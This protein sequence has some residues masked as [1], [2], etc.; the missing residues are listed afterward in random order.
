MELALHQS[1][2]LMS[3]KHCSSDYLSDRFLHVTAEWFAYHSHRLGV[4]PSV[5]SSIT[6]MI[7]IKTMQ[8]RI[9]KSLLCTAWKTLVYRDEISC[10]WMKGFS[11]N[12]GVKEGYPSW[13]DVILPILALLMWKWFQIDTDMLLIITVNGY[14]LLILLTLMTL[15][16]LEPPEEGFLV[17]FLLQRT[18]QEWI[19]MKCLKIDEGNLRMKF[20]ALN[21]DISS[22]SDDPLS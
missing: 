11:S 7:C 6:L 3:G 5:C 17:N 14:R 8:T 22:P 21:T 10:P 2:G 15:N 19:A 13:Q 4:C 18:F 16:D 1:L 9:M 12:E 20:S